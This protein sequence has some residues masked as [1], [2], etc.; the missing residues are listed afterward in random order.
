MHFEACLAGSLRLP[1]TIGKAAGAADRLDLAT[2]VGGPAEE[3]CGRAV[4]R[5]EVI[6]VF[7][8]LRALNSPGAVTSYPPQGNGQ[9]K[10]RDLSG[11]FVGVSP[12]VWIRSLATHA[13]FATRMNR[14]SGLLQM[15]FKTVPVNI[16]ELHE[17][18][19]RTTAGRLFMA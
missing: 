14:D 18:A 1:C 10:N 12:R 2:D 11:C 13:A 16:V 19:L 7:A 4:R 3:Y 5:V 9:E 15:G 6:P 8:L 17:R